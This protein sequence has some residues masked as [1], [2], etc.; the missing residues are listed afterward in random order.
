MF[1]LFERGN[2]G[3]YAVDPVTGMVAPSLGDYEKCILEGRMALRV[4][5]FPLSASG[6]PIT[7]IYLKTIHRVKNY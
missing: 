1:F 4:F 6:M 7:N 2:S 5:D 3:N